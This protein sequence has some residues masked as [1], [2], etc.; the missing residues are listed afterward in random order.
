MSEPTIKCYVVT[1]TIYRSA[2]WYY[3]IRNWETW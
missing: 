1:T 3:K 2:A